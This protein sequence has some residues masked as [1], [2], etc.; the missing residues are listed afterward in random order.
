VRF[1]DWLHV[2]AGVPVD[3]DGAYGPQCTDLVNDYLRQV[4][5]LPPLAGNAIDFQRDHLSSWLWVPNTPAVRPSTG[6]VV[7]WNGP[8][9][10]VG[11][12]EAGHAAVALL[13]DLSSLLTF[14]Q[15]WPAGHAP[16]QVRHSY[17]AVA[18]WF[19]PPSPV[20]E[21]T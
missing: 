1:L 19:Y 9:A 3:T 16:Q 5:S 2:R 11:T 14:D 15:N 8:N 4:W 21:R 12:G 17:V 18:G 20:L 7:V 6:A 10:V 13:S